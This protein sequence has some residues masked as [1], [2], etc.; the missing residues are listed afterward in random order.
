MQQVG[1]PICRAR[2]RPQ[3]SGRAS[4]NHRKVLEGSPR[5]GICTWGHYPAS[6]LLSLPPLGSTEVLCSPPSFTIVLEIA[7]TRQS[8][9]NPASPAVIG[10]RRTS[11][12]G[13]Q[14]IKTGWRNQGSASCVRSHLS[15]APEEGLAT[16]LKGG[17]GEG[18]W[19][20]VLKLCPTG[21]S[22]GTPEK[23]PPPRL[24]PRKPSQFPEWG[25]AAPF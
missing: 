3:T 4:E 5:R 14:S 13:C 7:T 16:C 1:K 12:P 15:G 6:L 10:E 9:A 17:R 25:Q 22:R 8:P 11:S 23:H 20:V 18:S 24:H 2:K 21:A 19:S